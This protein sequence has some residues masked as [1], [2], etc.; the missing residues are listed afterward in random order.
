MKKL[1]PLLL[2]VVGLQAQTGNIII[3]AITTTAIASWPDDANDPLTIRGYN[4]YIAGRLSTNQVSAEVTEKQCD[5][6]PLLLQVPNGE[7]IVW[8][9]AI[10]LA[11]LESAPSESL[12]F[13]WYGHPPNP[14]GPIEISF[15]KP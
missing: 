9:T 1:I 11:G 2:L 15:I 14:P 6:I 13:F 4:V 5:L 12:Y 3:N 7:Y 10:N 8:A